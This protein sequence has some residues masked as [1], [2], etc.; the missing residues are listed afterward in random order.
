MAHLNALSRFHVL[1]LYAINSDSG[2]HAMAH[3]QVL[4]QKDPGPLWA[5]PDISS[6]ARSPTPPAPEVPGGDRRPP[7]PPLG[8]GLRDDV[9]WP[10][11]RKFCEPL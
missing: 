11:A 2:S 9:P 8:V 3:L 4:L 10:K 7:E 5:L 6:V 1:K